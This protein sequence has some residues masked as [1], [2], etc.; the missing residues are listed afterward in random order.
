MANALLLALSS[1]D[2]AIPLGALILS[3]AA[4]IYGVMGGR[5]ETMTGIERAL[6]D[7]ITDLSHQVSELKIELRECASQR[8]AVEREN[9]ELM[10]QVFK[11]KNGGDS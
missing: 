1:S 7:R 3:A 10:R 5:S 6:N 9:V 11:L 2:F 8:A 4:L